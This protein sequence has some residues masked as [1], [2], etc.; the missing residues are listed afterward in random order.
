[1]PYYENRGVLLRHLEIWLRYPPSIRR[2]MTVTIADDGSPNNPAADCVPADYPIDVRI[3]RALVD[4][5]WNQCGARN[6]A[7]H[8]APDD[9]VLVTD[10]DHV[11]EPDEARKI[12][13][14]KVQEGCYYIPD[15]RRQV[16]RKPYKRHPNSYYLMRSMYWA[17]GGCDEDFQGHYG[18]DSTFRR[19]LE[20]HGR[21]VEIDACLT[22]YGREV[23]PDAS[24][25][26]WGRKDSEYSSS[27][28]PELRAK[29]KLGAYI[30]ER[31]LRFPWA[32]VR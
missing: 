2:T 26:A 4:L 15:R 21:R 11:L 22:L 16:D 10:I 24:T 3:Y 6:L 1:M 31:P 28:V 19:S 5:P 13:A 7:M 27:L 20:P 25:T 32:R 18:S 9:W 23:I 12:L 30:A 17:T 8:H 14:L 29:R